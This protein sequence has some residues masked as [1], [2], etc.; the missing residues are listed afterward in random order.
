MVDIN[1][2]KRRGPSIWPWIV[3]LGVLALLV[4]GI[5]ALVNTRKTT[6]AAEAPASGSMPAAAPAAVPAPAAP[7]GTTVSLTTLLPLGP[8][9]AG[10]HV[11]TS[12]VVVGQPTGTGFWLRAGNDV[13]W[14]E[15]NAVVKRGEELATVSGTLESET[16]ADANRHIQQASLRPERGWTVQRSLYLVQQPDGSAPPGGTPGAPAGSGGS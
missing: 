16:A 3:G 15:S 13:V 12:G 1:L 14:V 7:T 5:A 4:W 9:D 2:E 10:Q 6:E 8:E 11:N